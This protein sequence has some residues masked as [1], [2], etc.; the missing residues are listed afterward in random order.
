[1]DD[2]RNWDVGDFVLPAMS[3]VKT[4]AQILS[5]TPVTIS[6]AVLNGP[7]LVDSYVDTPD[8]KTQVPE[9]GAVEV[10]QL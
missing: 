2:D 1:M 10:F 7:L 4:Q 6:A 5:K 9:K 3:R 8:L